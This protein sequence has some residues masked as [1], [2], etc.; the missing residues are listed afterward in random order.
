MQNSLPG[1]RVFSD[2]VLLLG[3]QIATSEAAAIQWPRGSAPVYRDLFPQMEFQA[4]RAQFDAQPYRIREELD[5]R[6]RPLTSAPLFLER[7]LAGQDLGPARQKALAASFYRLGASYVPL[8]RSLGLTPVANGD[9]DDDE[10]L[11]LAPTEAAHVLLARRLAVAVDRAPTPSRA[12]CDAYLAAQ[13]LSLK[14]VSSVLARPH[15]EPLVKR[16]EACAA[17]HPSEALHYETDLVRGLYAAGYLEPTLVRL[18]ALRERGAFSQLVASDAAALAAAGASLL[19]RAERPV[20]ALQW[21][22]EAYRLSPAELDAVRLIWALSGKDR[23]S[24]RPAQAPVNAR[25]T[26]AQQVTGRLC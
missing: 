14:E 17:A 18:L 15:P 22:Q 8:A 19:L 26:L 20:E 2:P 7:Y 6:V 21:A 5:E 24:P 11:A 1:L 9:D 10:R 23:G 16:L 4:A 25:R 12:A 13:A 3:T